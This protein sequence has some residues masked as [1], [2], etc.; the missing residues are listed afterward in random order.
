M[1]RLFAKHAQSPF[2]QTVLISLFCATLQAPKFTGENFYKNR[3]IVKEFQELARKKGATLS[4]IAIAWVCANGMIPIPG[5]T[6]IKRLEENFASTGIEFT[7][8]E[9]KEMRS[10]VD[11]AKPSGNR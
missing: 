10:L 3:A 1:P 5:T 2:R 6:K 11:S 8:E 7:P 9:F 4:Q